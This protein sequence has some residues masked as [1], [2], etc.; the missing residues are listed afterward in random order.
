MR[1]V[2][3]LLSIAATSEVGV[4]TTFSL[5]LGEVAS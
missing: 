2:C 5:R 4:G 1:F 3:C